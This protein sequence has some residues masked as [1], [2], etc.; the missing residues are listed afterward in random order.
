MNKYFRKLLI[1]ALAITMVI[2][3]TVHFGAVDTDND[4]GLVGNDTKGNQAYYCTGCGQYCPVGRDYFGGLIGSNGYVHYYSMTSTSTAGQTCFTTATL[5]H[6]GVQC[7]FDS[8]TY[9][10]GAY[11]STGSF[12][13]ILT[14]FSGTCG[15]DHNVW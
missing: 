12:Q 3:M 5:Y 15:Q 11:A 4:V 8:D 13:G 9:V 1:V 6:L 2:S 14:E 10:N 7:D